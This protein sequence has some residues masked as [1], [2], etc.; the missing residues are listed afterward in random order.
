MKSHNKL[1]H[2]FLEI[3]VTNLFFVDKASS[4][5][6]KQGWLLRLTAILGCPKKLIKEK[7]SSLFFHN[8][9]DYQKH[10]SA[11]KPCDNVIKLLCILADKEAE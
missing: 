11:L 3:F 8:A 2:L 7:H 6:S 1:E 4:Q 10:F 5:L 9:S